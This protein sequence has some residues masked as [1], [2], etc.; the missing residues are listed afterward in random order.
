[1]P[2]EVEGSIWASSSKE[3]G[4][5]VGVQ[6]I[7]PQAFTQR[8]LGEVQ[9]EYPILVQLNGSW[10]SFF[11]DKNPPNPNDVSKITQGAPARLIVGGSADMVANNLPFMLN[12]ADWMVEDEA[13]I[14][15]RSKIIRLPQMEEID[16]S[17]EHRYKLFNLL[18]GSLL[19][20]L[21]GGIRI[22]LRRRTGGL[23]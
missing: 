2:V 3:S 22:F 23:S 18:A 19:V 17:R 6:T 9:G 14:N 4:K 21:L 7:N 10:G 1:M 16:A 5:I 12:L 20:L 8:A 15:I 11:A 13:L